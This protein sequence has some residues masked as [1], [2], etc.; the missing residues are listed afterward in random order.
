MTIKQKLYEYCINTVEE[1]I[2]LATAAMEAAQH[3]ANSETKSSA[4]DKY[5]TGRAMAHLDKDRHA[6]QLSMALQTRQQLQQLN[7]NLIADTISVGSLVTT[8]AGRFFISVGL[9]SVIINDTEYTLISVDS[10]LGQAL[11]DKEE[12]DIVHFRKR[13]FEIIRIE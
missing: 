7:P 6:R 11:L 12:E 2:T 9:G 13:E 1:Q 5:E 3:A 4:G 10:P 8:N